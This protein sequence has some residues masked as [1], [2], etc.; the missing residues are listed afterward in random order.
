MSRIIRFDGIV[1][2][3]FTASHQVSWQTYVPIYEEDIDGNSGTP[4][5]PH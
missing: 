2:S 5:D 1:F 4:N 3:V